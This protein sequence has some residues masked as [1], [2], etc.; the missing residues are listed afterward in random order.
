MESRQVG[1]TFTR[2]IHDKDKKSKRKNNKDKCNGG[3]FCTK[4]RFKHDWSC[5]NNEGYMPI[6]LIDR[7]KWLIQFGHM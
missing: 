3:K 6:R 1:K 2:F 4:C 5:V 7:I